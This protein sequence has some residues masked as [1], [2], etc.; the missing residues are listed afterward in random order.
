MPKTLTITGIIVAI[1]LLAVFAADLAIGLPFGKASPAMDIGIV[2]CSIIV[3]VLGWL[4]L[5]EL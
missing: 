5:K 3:L 4:T 2:I 1:A